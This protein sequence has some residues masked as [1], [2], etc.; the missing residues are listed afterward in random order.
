MNTIERVIEKRLW[1]Q[2]LTGKR[3]STADLISELGQSFK[4]KI[5]P[6]REIRIKKLIE[7]VQERV[8]KRH[9]RYLKRCDRLQDDLLVPDRLLHRWIDLGLIDP[10]DPKAN[11]RIVIIVRERDFFRELNLDAEDIPDDSSIALWD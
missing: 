7:K 8:R 4:T 2:R 9:S 5:T 1:R 6:A 11:G 3:L 10:M